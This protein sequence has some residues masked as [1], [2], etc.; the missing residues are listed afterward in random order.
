M[1]NR[2]ALLPLREPITPLVREALDALIERTTA[3]GYVVVTFSRGGQ[4]HI[5]AVKAAQP[6]HAPELAGVGEES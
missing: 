3:K 6:E 1:K 2:L 4:L 5:A